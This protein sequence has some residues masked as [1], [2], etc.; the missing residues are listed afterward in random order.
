MFFADELEQLA[1]LGLLDELERVAVLERREQPVRHV[2]GLA[3]AERPLEDFLGVLDAALVDVLEG[4]R[5]LVGLG[6][7][8]VALVDRDGRDFRDLE[9]DRFDFVLTQELEDRRRDLQAE[10]DHENG[11]LLGARHL[12]NG[13]VLELIRRLGRRMLR[14]QPAPMIGLSVIMGGWLAG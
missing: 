1:G 6:D 10:R 9:D 2:V 11:G 8:R 5:A 4:D 14:P 12:R 3:G 7:D 13:R